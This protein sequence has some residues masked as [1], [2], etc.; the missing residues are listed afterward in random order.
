MNDSH[1]TEDASQPDQPALA[2]ADEALAEMRLSFDSSV[3][4]RTPS[5]AHV[6]GFAEK[7]TVN[8]HRNEDA[9]KLGQG[10]D[11]PVDVVQWLRL[12]LMRTKQENETLTTKYNNLVAKL[13]TMRNSVESKLK[14]D[15]VSD[16]IVFLAVPLLVL[17]PTLGRAG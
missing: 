13:A 10:N 9:E 1:L 8:G 7:S 12:E 16:I 6:N 11:S 14:R 2:A 4:A 5:P 15:A 17:N 3:G